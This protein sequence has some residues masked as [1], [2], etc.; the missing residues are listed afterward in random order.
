MAP[1]A[2][3]HDMGADGQDSCSVWVQTCFP[4]VKFCCSRACVCIAVQVRL[5][6]LLVCIS[7]CIIL[8]PVLCIVIPKSCERCRNLLVPFCALLF[9][10]VVNCVAACHY[11]GT[12]RVPKGLPM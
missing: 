11:C 4:S 6:L 3:S 5:P 8:W 10:C 2:I 7:E 9:K 1:S 12:T